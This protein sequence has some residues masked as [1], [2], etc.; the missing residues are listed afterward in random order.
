MQIKLKTQISFGLLFLIF[1]TGCTKRYKF[2]AKICDKLYVEVYEVNYFGV[3]ADYLTD[4]IR[5]KKYIGKFDAEHETYRYWCSGDSI[6][7]MKTVRGNRWAKWD[8]TADGKMTVISNL[9]T[10]ENLTLGISQLKK[11]NNLGRFL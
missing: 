2:T 1:L 11:E 10:I 3:D 5:F 6:Y 7:V 4:S 9:D 8:T